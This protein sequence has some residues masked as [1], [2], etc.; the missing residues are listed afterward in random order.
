MTEHLRLRRTHVDGFK[1]FD[2]KGQTVDFG[3]VTVFL[4]ANGAGKS[5][6]VSFFMMLH[7]LVAGSLQRFVAENGGGDSLLYFGAQRTPRLR[8]GV[9]FKVGSRID[10]YKFSLV[11]AAGDILIFTHE[12]IHHL[13]GGGPPAHIELGAGQKETG[14][15]AA[16]EQGE[17]RCQFLLDL[18]RTCKVFQFHDTSSTAR[19]RNQ[20]YIDDNARL[21]HDA[22]N[23]AAFLYALRN[24]ERARK[25]YDRIVR[26]IQGILPQFS[27]FVLEP[28]ALNDRY[29]RLNWY[30]ANS[31]YL[32]GPHQLSDGAL[33]FM[34]LTTLLMQPPE[35]LP[36]VIV[37]DEPEL[38]LHP[39][40]IA[41]LAGMVRSAAKQ[42]QVV[43]A[44]Q[45][46][47][48]V[49]EFRPEE[50]VV[51]EREENP[52]RSVCRRLE[53]EALTEWLSRYSLSELWEKNVLGGRP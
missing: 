26:R 12:D 42:C 39:A 9:A 11:H 53:P 48:L 35:T 5:N 25:Y 8:G 21:H 10:V 31:D 19:I 51:V 50:I 4:G 44:T 1:S 36:R 2:T 20:G 15:A 17:E 13:D 6:V 29:I 3:D 22:G 24:R 40:A 46:T 41:S 14:L 30:E 18:L 37:V 28:S 16:A 49:D 27:D 45:S 47:R 34:A 33:R 52:P 38:G 32:F 43:L 23:L 7:H